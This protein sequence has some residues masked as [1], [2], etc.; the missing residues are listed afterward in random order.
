MPAA[1]PSVLPYRSKQS[2]GEWIGENVRGGFA[3]VLGIV[4]VT[5]RRERSTEIDLRGPEQPIAASDNGLAVQ[6][7]GDAAARSPLVR[8]VVAYRIRRATHP[9]V[10]YRALQIQAGYL[11]RD[12]IGRSLIEAHD[13]TV[14]LFSYAA[15]MF[16]AQSAIDGDLVV[17]P[18]IVLDEDAVVGN[19]I[20]QRG[21]GI[22]LAIVRQSQKK[23]REIR[24]AVARS[25]RA[26][27]IERVAAGGAVDP[28]ARGSQVTIVEAC[29]EAV[30]AYEFV[31]HDGE[32][33]GGF[34]VVIPV[35][36]IA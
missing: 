33:V 12:R 29:A 26:V 36:R 31:H 18:E 28:G 2:S 9:C 6:L 30:S 11:G 23:I 24:P 22:R 8:V 16:P 15:L 5:E 20:G 14:V 3:G 4:R 35:A 32:V 17:Q 25:Q 7:P 10:L 13:Q 21:S 19:D 27:R 1:A 34:V